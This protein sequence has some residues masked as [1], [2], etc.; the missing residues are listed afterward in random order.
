M[1]TTNEMTKET[2]MFVWKLSS[3]SWAKF[4]RASQWFHW[5]VRAPAGYSVC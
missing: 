5:L 2:K 3:C 1:Q 4:R